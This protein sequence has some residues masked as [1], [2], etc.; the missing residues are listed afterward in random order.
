MVEG[1][2]AGAGATMDKIP[3]AQALAMHNI[4]ST[5]LS[6]LPPY[7]PGVEPL[8]SPSPSS[9]SFKR[10]RSTVLEVTKEAGVPAVVRLDVRHGPSTTA[11]IDMAE[12]ESAS[13]LDDSESDNDSVL[14]TGMDT[15]RPSGDGEGSA[16]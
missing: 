6:P 12:A 2:S 1:V 16:L 13:V 11:E 10:L 4:P 15:E 7:L 3:P 9:S 8:P 5:P 14:S